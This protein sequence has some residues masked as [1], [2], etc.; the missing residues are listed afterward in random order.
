M[1]VSGKVIV[2]A[3][4]NEEENDSGGHCGGERLNGEITPFSRSDVSALD[5]RV[6]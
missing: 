4:G 3:E 2:G 1:L 6:R 5:V